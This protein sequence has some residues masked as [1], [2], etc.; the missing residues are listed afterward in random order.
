[1]GVDREPLSSLTR[2]AAPPIADPEPCGPSRLASARSWF[3]LDLKRKAIADWEGGNVESRCGMVWGMMAGSG[4]AARRWLDPE[5]SG[6]I[7]QL[8]LGE[9]C[10]ERA[11]GRDGYD[12]GGEQRSGTET[13]LER[14]DDGWQSISL[15]VESARAIRFW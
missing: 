5:A 4:A 1:M 9:R 3:F 12:D 15:V 14:R 13:T 7:V 8:P 2:A 10:N 11:D 6:G